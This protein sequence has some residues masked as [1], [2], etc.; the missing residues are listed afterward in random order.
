MV[1]SRLL[2]LVLGQS[3]GVCRL[4]FGEESLMYGGWE[5]D[6]EGLGIPI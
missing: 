1:L 4:V 5:C 6:G 3:N 2:L